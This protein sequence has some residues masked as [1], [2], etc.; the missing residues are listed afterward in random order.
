M[1]GRDR[2]VRY[3][4]C[5]LRVRDGAGT[6]RR[7]RGVGVHRVDPFDTGHG[8]GVPLDDSGGEF[9]VPVVRRLRQQNRLGV[10]VDGPVPAV[11]RRAVGDVDAGG[12]TLVD[13]ATGEVGRRVAGGGDV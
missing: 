11:R 4:G 13:E 2:R 7:E 12:Q 6:P 1:A 3:A 8:V 5:S 9:V 10:L